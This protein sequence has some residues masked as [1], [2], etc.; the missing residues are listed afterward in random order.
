ME[1]ENCMFKK[2]EMLPH[3]VG[4]LKLN[5][6]PDH[7]RLPVDGNRCHGFLERRDAIIFDLRDNRG[8]F[9]NMVC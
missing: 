1:Q 5:F 7:L 2:V 6:F 3:N 9:P 8:G 4:Y